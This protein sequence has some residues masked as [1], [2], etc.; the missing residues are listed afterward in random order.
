M[1]AEQPF[2]T[3]IIPIRNEE[4]FIG[5]AL[6]SVLAQTYRNLDVLVIDGVSTDRTLDVVAERSGRDPRV[7]VVTNP[8][9]TTMTGLNLGLREARGE[10]LVRV[11][12]HATIPPDYVDKAM[13]HLLTGKWGGVGGRKDAVGITPAGRAI[14]AAMSSSFGVGNSTYHHGTEPTT[15]DHIPFGSYPTAIARELGG[16]D[17][18]LRA[19]E[20]YEF[21]LRLRESGRPLLFDPAL[22]IAWVCRQSNADLFK[23]YVRYGRGKADVAV[24]HPKSLALRH[25]IPPLFLLSLVAAVVLFAIGLPLLGALPVVAYAA[26]IA[27]GTFTTMGKVQRGERRHLP[28]AFM[29]M[30]IGWAYGFWTGLASRLLGRP[31]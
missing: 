5:E 21:D 9:S 28:F 10:W 17:E 1:P 2:V 7:R 6:D 29:A 14:A 25:L 16:W 24:L 3:V 30:H 12:G 11:D 22:R 18:T 31:T 15:V 20:D 27:A 19:N 4:G 26:L 23:Q 13:A 8:A